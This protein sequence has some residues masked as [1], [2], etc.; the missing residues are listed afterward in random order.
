MD[1]DNQW[2]IWHEQCDQFSGCSDGFEDMCKPFCICCECAVILFMCD[3]KWVDSSRKKPPYRAA[4][5][6][7]LSYG[8]TIVTIDKNG[9]V[10]VACCRHCG[11]LTSADMTIL[12]HYLIVLRTFLGSVSPGGWQ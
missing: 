6:E 4:K 8:L 9:V 1:A 2:S 7:N 12:D 3:I 11:N 10:K 5:F